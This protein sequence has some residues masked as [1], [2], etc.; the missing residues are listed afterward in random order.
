MIYWLCQN[1]L[2][3]NT[4]A[5]AGMMNTHGIP[6]DLIPDANAIA[7]ILLLPLVTHGLNPL[8]RHYRVGFGPIARIS[9]GFMIEAL[10]MGYAAI[11]QALIYAA[12]PCYSRP[13][14]CSASDGGKIPN[15]V[16][17]AVQLPV[18]VLEGLSEIFS[19][20][21]FYE[22]AY[23]KAPRSMKSFVQ[24]IFSVTTVFG[25]ALA[26]ALAPTYHNPAL[27]YMY[28]SLGC[29][30]GLCAIVTYFLLCR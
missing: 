21:A 23:T 9:L 24:A 5:Q 22:Y 20:P 12:P 29:T 16:N 13:L 6:N 1:Q 18:Y 17:N 25:S 4:I 19:N 3:S 28:T 10:A 7:V 26:I 2:T 11:V 14:V 30:M 8:L 15:N 27:M